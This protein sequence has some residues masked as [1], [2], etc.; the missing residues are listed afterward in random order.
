MLGTLLVCDILVCLV[1]G[2]KISLTFQR[3]GHGFLR[4]Y[5]LLAPIHHTDEPEFERVCP[6]GQ[7]IIGICP[8]I[9][10]IELS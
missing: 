8:G 4:I 7:D 2:K 5:I 3:C 10:E 1:G 6:S 9:H